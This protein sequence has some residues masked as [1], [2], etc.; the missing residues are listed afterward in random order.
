MLLA[1]TKPA[2][3]QWT[4]SGPTCV[5]VGTQYT[6]TISGSWTNSTQM[7]WTV[8]NGTGSASGTPLPQ[9]HV[10]WSGSG[11]VQINT[12]N[13]TGSYSLPVTASSTVTG[14]T[15]TPTSQTIHYG[16]TPTNLTCTA[17]GGGSCNNPVYS[18]QWQSSP[19]NS[20]FSNIAGATATNITFT[21]GLTQTTYYRRFVTETVSG[22]TNYSNTATVIVSPQLV[23]TIG[24]ASQQVFTGGTITSLGGSVSGGAC[25]SPYSYQWQSSTD[26]TN[27]TSISTNG[28][29][30]SYSPTSTAGLIYYRRMVSDCSGSETSY[31]SAATVN[32]QAHLAAGTILPAIYSVDPNTGSTPISAPASTG[33]FCSPYSYQWYASPGGSI[34][35][36][37]SQNY[38]VPPLATTSSYYRTTICGSETQSTNTIV[39]NVNIITGAITPATQQI[40]NGATPGSLTIGTCKGG[41]GA[42]SYSWWSSPDASF[43]SP[44]ALGSTSATA[45]LPALTATTYFRAQVSSNG[46]AAYS[47]PVVVN[48]YPA[49]V[50]GTITSGS[51]SCNAGS[52]PGT[53]TLTGVSGGN[54]AYTYQWYSNASGSYQ[55]IAGA[56]GTTYTPGPLTASTSYYVLVTS[57]GVT[58]QTPTVTETV[59]PPP[60]PAI[61]PGTISPSGLTI[62]SGANPGALSVSNATGGS[63][64]GGLSYQWQSS[65]NNAS[66]TNVGML[67]NLTYSPGNLTATMYYRVALTC[68]STTLYTN[69]AV[70]TI[71]TP[72]TDLSYIRARSLMK[73][74]VFDTATAN[75]LT[76]SSDVQQSTTYF[77][78]FGRSV[79]TVARQAS[80]LQMDMV[81]VQ[82]YDAFGR[83]ALHYLPYTSA[84]SDGNFKTDP[85]SEQS[86]FNAAQFPTDQYFYG[87]SKFEASPL[88][89]T[90][91]AY[92]AGNSWVGAGRGVGS[93]YLSNTVADSVHS[94]SIGYTTGS[95]AID[96]GLYAAGTLYKTNTT[97]E[98]NNQVV[99]YKDLNGLVI[100]KKVQSAA[101]PGTAHVGW[102]CTYYVYDD[103]N[104][105]RFVIPPR[106]VE[107][108]NVTGTWTIASTIASELCFRYE[109]DVRGRMIVKKVPGAGEAHMVYDE[110]D[111][112]VMTQDSNL[113]FQKQW[114][115]TCYDALNR[116][117]STGLMTD[118]TNYN[119]LSYHTTAAMQNAT[120]PNLSGYTVQLMT[121]NFY[122]DYTWV[123]ATSAP[124]L[125]AF[126]ASHT[127][128]GGWFLTSYN[129]SPVYDVQIIPFYITRGMQTGVAKIVI[130]TTSQFLYTSMFYDDRGRTIQTSSNNYLA[131]K[132]T[133]TNQ[134]NFAG[135]VLRSLHSQSK[136]NNGA[137]SHMILTRMDYDQVNRLKAVYKFIDNV[138]SIQAISSM[139]YDE[140][141]RL[142]AKYLG[143]SL[144]S[145]I[146]SYNIRGWV[147]GI[148]KNYA[149]GTTNHWFGMELA[150]DNASSVT[151]TTY[152]TPQFN[153]NIAG[154]IWKSR[155]DAI[156]RKYDFTYDNVNRL[157]G[158]NFNQ[159]IGGSWGK[160]SGGS[161]PV[162]IDFSVSGLGY[163]A[164]GNI[165]SMIQ[166]GFK[167]GGTGTPIDSL[168]YTYSFASSPYTNKLSQ[169]H[170]QY[171]DTAS[172]LGD[173]HYK[174][175]K[176]S[177]DYSYDGNGNLA[178]DKNKAL[179]SLYYNYLN[180]LG[181]A[182]IIGKGNINYVYDAGGT[183]LQKQV[184][185][186]T[187]STVTYT[188][189][190]GEFQY[191]RRAPFSSPYG[192]S[193]TLQFISTEEGRARWAFHKHVA[194]DTIT[195]PEYDFVERDHLGNER[196][197][198]TQQRDTT[199]YVATME[200]AN[201]AT[202][203]ALFYNIGTTCVARSSVP[204]PGYPNDLTYTNPNDSVSKLNGNGPTV[205]PAI[206]LK[207]MSG[208]IVDVG[209]QYY[210]NTGSYTAG[211]LSPQN[212]LNSLASGLASL[213]SAASESIT[214]LT[215]PTTSPLLSA[216]MSSVNNQS[217]T[218][219]STPQAYLNWVLLDKQFRYVAGS[220]GALQV[221]AAGQNGGAL[222]PPLAQKTIT[223]SQSGYLYIYVSNAT[224]GWDVFFDN[225]SVHLGLNTVDDESANLR[226]H[227]DDGNLTVGNVAGAIAAIGM[228]ATKG[229]EGGPVEINIDPNVHP[230]AAA[231]AE[232]AMNEGVSGEGVIDRAGKNAR[233]TENLSG[234]P[235]KK[236]AD[237]DEFP[238]AVINNGGNGQSVQYINPS[239]NRGAG[240][241][242]GHQIQ[243]LPDGTRVVIRIPK[244]K[245]K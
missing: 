177:G 11:T 16:A 138:A 159:Y 155:G 24:P 194:G 144:D 46:Y 52:T 28:Q 245:D 5:T 184:K 127:T 234:I 191:T 64:S 175:V 90:A 7:T 231:H 40:N 232:Q 110:R 161:S 26:G 197:I 99:E 30:A 178:L 105:L 104:L 134:Y 196:V 87:Y 72:N 96:G 20:N 128:T 111:R 162:T 185:D 71:G 213:S 215:N 189:Y 240:S 102:L 60:T 186:S 1:M 44:T 35:G 223:M 221:G 222:Q 27:Y 220:S 136:V 125:S 48:V 199:Q 54:S 235:T 4:I 181:N 158:A 137:Q 140:L 152:A 237:R 33:G 82:A 59:I 93:Q 238:P 8:S 65:T 224:K 179:N 32:V 68:G 115:F 168:T 108:I 233:R 94:W 36:A 165:Q 84:A 113:R 3:T 169:V 236:G 6:Y 226:T 23:Q 100:L 135:M 212:L 163:D 25:G 63:C 109:Y 180:L 83:E 193:D 29:S 12:S 66:W 42:Y 126:D 75:G 47:D 74:Q 88:S 62:V 131:G 10:T 2:Y 244:L 57:N 117:D 208:D 77:D 101:S 188:S 192:G 58:A 70:I 187:T 124:V 174:G 73:A 86:T 19:D 182:H 130:N 149:G 202:E 205:G 21:A 51:F 143:N 160:T 69:T 150:Y 166:Q 106:A 171:N 132:D 225:M 114:L 214:T 217:G 164:N 210:Y 153:G 31:S 229:T 103:L 13:P 173:F 167:I 216:L 67:N 190:L 15:L 243:N 61:I 200:A 201:R 79:Q 209:T 43:S 17:S 146:Y 38:T 198:L 37:T 230:E 142:N 206:I 53:M 242:I 119:N 95:V 41:N 118:P 183:K 34:S 172:V 139:Q 85:N 89:R 122:D 92:A 45:T 204:A 50:A 241:S 56:T 219:T 133:I 78:G 154:V 157:T 112:L 151:G 239:D 80:P 107:V 91:A 97:D 211:S 9:I 129:G 195:Y 14:G 176:G 49:L 147:T 120:Y 55:V 145:L 116:A 228:A 39:V 98:Q 22:T 156:N 18:Y 76:S 81:T 218:G 203:N 170:D 207:V 121:R 123:A 148:N 227:A 141:G